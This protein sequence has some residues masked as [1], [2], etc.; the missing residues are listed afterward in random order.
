MSFLRSLSVF[1][2]SSIFTSAIFI[3]ITSYTLGNLIQKESIKGFLDNEGTKIINQQCDEQC[4]QYTSNRT[5][6]L[7]D[8]EVY[9]NNQ[10]KTLIGAVTDEIYQR[11][12]FGMNLNEVSSTSSEYLIFLIIGIIFGMLLLVASE[13]PFSTLGKNLIT[14]SISLFILYFA[15]NFIIVFVNLPLDLGKDFIDYLSSGLNL[16]A[17]YGI[18]LLAMGIVLVAVNYA[19]RK[20]K[21]EKAGKEKK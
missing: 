1:I 4:K 3:A 16:S 17:K 9:L 19:I 7:Q 21:S 12:F 15:M 18:V 13:T 20:D 5:E 10:T 6:C 8:C 11:N 2:L 14:I